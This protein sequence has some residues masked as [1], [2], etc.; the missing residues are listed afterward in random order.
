VTALTI[1]G[2]LTPALKMVLLLQY[3]EDYTSEQIAR[4][5]GLSVPAVKSRLMRARLKLRQRLA[6]HFRVNEVAPQAEP[7][8]VEELTEAA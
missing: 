7:E 1:F 3:L 5:L 8:V 2:W 4:K 6:K